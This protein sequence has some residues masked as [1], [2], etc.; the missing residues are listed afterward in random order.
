M[1]NG[2]RVQRP[3]RRQVALSVVDLD[4]QLPDDHMARTVWAFVE[5][6]DVSALEAGIKSR[7][8]KPGRPT[9]DRRLYLALWLYGTLDG[10]GSARELDRLCRDHT[11]Y[12][13]LCGGVPVNYHDLSDFRVECGAFLDD[14]LSRS[15]AALVSQGL[16]SLDCLAV[17]SV[18]VR[19][20]AGA[21]SFHQG[22][23][24]NELHKAAQEKVEALRQEIDGDPGASAKRLT[25]RRMSA[26]NNRAEAIS[27]AKAAL[28]QIEAERAKEAK[29]QR[30]KKPK[31]KDPRASTTDADARV[32]K[33]DGG[34]RPGYSI[35]M[36]TDPKSGI[37]VGCAATN[38]AS[39]R[40]QL[41]SAVDDIERRYRTGPNRILADGGYDSK[42][43][44]EH[45]HAAKMDV[46][47][48][49]PRS[50]A[51]AAS[52]AKKPGDGPG[53]MAWRHRMATPDG[54]A[55]Y[56][57]RFAMERPH[58]HMRNRGFRL[59]NVRGLKKVFAA[60]LWQVLAYNF[61]QMRFLIASHPISGS[62]ALATD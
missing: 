10:I 32:M 29:E 17:D 3:D 60:T 24:L 19:A 14:L 37:I 11:A 62:S 43:D 61:T 48:P 18:R 36:R 59:L 27:N 12:R 4:S 23:T 39:D 51:N 16:V 8:G 45:L 50:R 7:E 5:Q 42:A 34:F 49:V 20:S 9:P 38:H 31:N 52:P 44:I 46:F 55:I 1:T 15:V 58:A 53:V 56:R 35:Q 47:C 2:P 22:S 57:K 25:A 28:A 6:I 54:L 41:R 33:T 40:G 13:W 26:A 30:R 21:S